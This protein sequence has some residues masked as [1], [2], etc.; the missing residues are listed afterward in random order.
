MADPKRIQQ[1]ARQS[2]DRGDPTGWFDD[3]YIEAGGQPADV[4]WASLRPNPFLSKWLNEQ[5]PVPPGTSAL[6]IGAGLGDDAELLSS[7]GFDVTA[8]DI[9]ATATKWA[10]SRFPDTSVQYYTADLLEPPAEWVN[11]FDLVYESCTLQALPWNLRARAI[12]QIADFV[13]EGGTL[14]VTTF[15]RDADEEAGQLPWPLT[16]EEVAAFR[17]AGL[18]EVSFRD[19]RDPETGVRWFI[20]DYRKPW[21]PAEVR[22]GEGS[23]L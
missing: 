16:R 20:V 7:A 10:R 3:V 18:V 13:A 1:L 23:P 17:I 9:S 22:P 11:R 19:E 5:P 15:G 6:V 4:P 8:F 14:L 2:Y 12:V 21:S